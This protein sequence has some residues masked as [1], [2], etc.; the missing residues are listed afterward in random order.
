[1]NS[2]QTTNTEVLVPDS[3]HSQ[4]NASLAKDSFLVSTLAQTADWRLP[5][6]VVGVSTALFFVLLPFA[7]EQLAAMPAFIAGY[8]S[9]LIIID[10]IT[11]VLLFAQ[12]NILGLPAL[13]P[14]AIAYLFSACMAMAHA[15]SFPGLFAHTG[16]LGAT[17]QTTA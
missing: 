15:M 2:L 8:Q 14:L 10:L 12:F 11:A 5:L 6:W 9:A 4:D 13:L 16:L 17:P 3:S 1:M 7:Q